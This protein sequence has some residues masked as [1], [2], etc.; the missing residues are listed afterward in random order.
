MS[1]VQGH[2]A[3]DETHT[4]SGL[5]RAEPVF[6]NTPFYTDRWLVLGSDEVKGPGMTKGVRRERRCLVTIEA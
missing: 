2:S 3:P 6:R 4:Q 5:H 1:S